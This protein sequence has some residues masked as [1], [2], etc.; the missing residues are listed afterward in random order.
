MK[1]SAIMR[2]TVSGGKHLIRGIALARLAPA[3][4]AIA[5]CLTVGGGKL[6]AAGAPD[7]HTVLI[8]NSSVSGG[9]SSIEAQ[10][11]AAA[12]YTVEVVDDATW[13]AKTATE[14]HTYR[15]LILGDPTCSGS[16]ST[17]AAAEANKATWGSII[18]GNV[19][20]IGTDEVFHDSSGGRQVSRNGVRFAADIPGKTGMFISIS[21]YYHGVAP[22]TPVPVLSPFGAFTAT[23][24][25]CFN[26]AHIV[27]THP[28]LTGI[29]DA[30]LSN[31]GCSVHEAFDSFP[32]GF[33]AL[34][35]AENQ[36]GAGNRTFPDGTNGIP[37]ILARGEGLVVISDITLTP[38]SATNPVGTSHTL[39]AKVIT[40]VPSAG[41]PVVGTT[42]TFTVI[43]GPNTGTTGTGVTNAS[44]DA[45]FA[46]TGAGGAGTDQIKATF[47]DASSTL[48]TS[49]IATKLWIAA[50]TAVPDSIHICNGTSVT[51]DP[52][53]NDIG[54]GLTITGHTDGS[55]GTV[56]HTAT[57]VTYTQ[58]VPYFGSDSFTYTITNTGGSTATATVTVST[59]TSLVALK[60]DQVSGQPLGVVYKKFGI[61]SIVEGSSVAF[62]ADIVTDDGTKKVIVA[63]F[64]PTVLLTKGD[65]A[66]GAGAS[67]FKSFK[68]P[69]I[70]NNGEV[71]FLAAIGGATPTTNKGLWSNFGGM[72]QLVARNG[73]P[74][75]GIPGAILRGVKSA[76][77]TDGGVIFTG[78]LQIG[79]GSVTGGNDIA[80]WYWEPG[81]G[82]QL[83]F[84]EGQSM[85]PGG[86][87]ET[88]QNFK[89]LVSVAKSPGHGRTFGAEVTMLVKFVS[90]K[91]A[92]V[93]VS[94]GF[95]EIE[96]YTGGTLTSAIP[97]AVWKKF[98]IPATNQFG[99]YA[100]L[101]L[102]ENGLG[103]ISSAVNAAIFAGGGAATLDLIAQKGD[104]A[105][106]IASGKFASF[107][108]PVINS[109][110]D[111][112]F[113]AKAK[114]PGLNSTNNSGIW[115]G[116]AA[117]ISLVAQNGSPAT[118]VP[119]G[120]WATFTSL[121]LPDNLGPAFTA[122]LKLGGDITKTNN[123]G[124]W[125]MDDLGVLC[126]MVRTGDSLPVVVGS[127]R[128]VKKLTI[129]RSVGG[130]AGQGRAYNV[131]S[132]LIYRVDFTDKTQ[133]ILKIQFPHESGPPSLE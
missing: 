70:N 40:N 121:A 123:F 76:V 88:V 125:A 25:G 15:A 32:V 12:G 84:R 30:S 106:G 48:R 3:I 71:A 95:T 39:N 83:L 61:P 55:L 64:P 132:A 128:T 7:D 113:L 108:S 65:I 43:S 127:P 91:T 126:L 97:G 62:R 94:P 107:K 52:R 122:K 6:Q 42:V 120:L 85:S 27:A 56:S 77:I 90:G 2:R 67:T 44:G 101:G 118:D 31:W 119:G 80:L 100:F 5:G 66:P 34:A 13:G 16:V 60:G 38:G 81:D 104:D 115:F 49:N 114:G 79:P 22:G 87:P 78:V 89:A 68:D 103:G 36:A 8:L 111:V 105:P 129:L 11:A 110:N 98:G 117:A 50:L 10:E 82:S 96:V 102:L 4:L 131:D 92:I 109:N 41:T 33:N 54:S 24:V 29:T 14:F 58:T 28:A 59:L 93:E 46:Y 116:D 112:A 35:I 99:Q 75:P 19:I 57:S 73:S 1:L 37:Y 21:C 74:A 20:I 130:T 17:I 26:D 23:G 133:A 124:L 69:V 45:T 18:D 86:T 72:L 63:G 9:A 47:V 53:V 51:A